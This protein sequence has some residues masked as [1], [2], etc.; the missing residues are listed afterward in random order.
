MLEDHQGQQK[1]GFTLQSLIFITAVKVYIQL[2]F[3]FKG[4][5]PPSQT[6]EKCHESN[7]IM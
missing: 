4:I 2:F 7:L 6:A 3:F 5:V 1:K